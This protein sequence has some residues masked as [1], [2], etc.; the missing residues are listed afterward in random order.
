MLRLRGLL[1]F[2]SLTGHEVEDAIEGAAGKEPHEHE[3]DGCSATNAAAR[4]RAA[5]LDGFGGWRFLHMSEEDGSRFP[6]MHSPKRAA[7]AGSDDEGIV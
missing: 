3:D 2:E 6:Q 7:G 5:S 4:F 1:A